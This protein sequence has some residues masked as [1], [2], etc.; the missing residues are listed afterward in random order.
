LFNTLVHADVR[1]PRH[2]ERIFEQIFVTP[3]L[4]RRHHDAEAHRTGTNF[5]TIFSAWDR[6]F[7]TLAPT[8]SSDAII[9]GLSPRERSQRSLMSLLKLPLTDQTY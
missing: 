3:A 1:L 2:F 9:V 4:H 7:Q 5:G 8:T 6:L